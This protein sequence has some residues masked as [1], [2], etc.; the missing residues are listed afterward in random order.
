M[1]AAA[2]DFLVEDPELT[3]GYKRIARRGLC[4]F[5]VPLLGYDPWPSEGL[6]FASPPDTVSIAQQG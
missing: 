5:G 2:W 4:H 6:G 3:S 1:G